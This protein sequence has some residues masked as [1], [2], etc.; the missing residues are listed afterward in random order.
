MKPGIY[1]V[2]SCCVIVAL[3]GCGAT[4]PRREHVIG[5]VTLNGDP[6]P[7]GRIRFL[8]TDGGKIQATAGVQQGKFELPVDEGLPAGDYRVEI[9]G[10]ID[11]GFPIDDDIAYAK[12]NKKVP[13]P[14]PPVPAAFNRNSTLTATVIPGRTNPL[15]FPLTFKTSNKK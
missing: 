12:L 8:P 6:L 3:T 2:A 13:A 7:S 14:K 4:G 5:E 10:D 1:P 9:E 11:L 15:D